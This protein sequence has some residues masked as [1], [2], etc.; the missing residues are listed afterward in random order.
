MTKREGWKCLDCN[1]TTKS[2]NKI[3]MENENIRPGESIWRRELICPF[4]VFLKFPFVSLISQ[5][6]IELNKQHV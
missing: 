2:K 1:N 3:I 5:R 6:Q 4:F